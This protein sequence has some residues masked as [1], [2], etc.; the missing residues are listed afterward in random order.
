[1]NVLPVVIS[2]PHSGVI[3]PNHLQSQFL[4]NPQE[5]LYDGD[6]WTNLLYNFEKRVLHT[7]LMPIAR[8]VID[9]NRMEVDLPPNNEDGIVKTKSIMS[10]PVWKRPLSLMETQS[11]IMHYYT[12][13]FESLKEAVSIQKPFLGLDCHSMLPYDPFAAEPKKRPLICISN[14]GDVN[15]EHLNEPLS[16]PPALMLTFKKALETQFGINNVRINDPF[17]GGEIIRK[18]SES[19]NTPWIQIEVNRELY[20]PKG[21]L[22]MQEPDEETLKRIVDINRKLFAALES[23]YQSQTLMPKRKK[24]LPIEL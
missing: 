7:A 23:L 17:K 2:I 3:I 10:R 8:C 20:M 1:M 15:G 18:M 21:D 4:L 19:T 12:P 16:A 5:V 24:P 22:V 11:L 9:L 13:Y 14:R 6:S